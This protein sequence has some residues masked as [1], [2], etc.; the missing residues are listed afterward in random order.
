ME[1]QHRFADSTGEK[2][3]DVNPVAGVDM[4]YGGVISRIVTAP[5]KPDHEAVSFHR[6]NARTVVH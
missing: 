1:I 2:L 6:C 4:G 5:P 3:A